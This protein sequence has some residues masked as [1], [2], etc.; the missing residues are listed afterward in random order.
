MA[1]TR[2]DFANSSCCF[3]QGFSTHLDKVAV[4]SE[5]VAWINGKCFTFCTLCWISKNWLHCNAGEKVI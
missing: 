4:K 2:F 1:L 3:F 5:L